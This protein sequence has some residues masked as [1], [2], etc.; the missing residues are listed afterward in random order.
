MQ[1]QCILANGEQCKRI[2]V[3]GNLCWQHKN[4]CKKLVDNLPIEN[5]Q[6]DILSMDIQPN[7]SIKI[8]KYNMISNNNNSNNI[9]QS[10]ILSFKTPYEQSIKIDKYNISSKKPIIKQ[11]ENYDKIIS[12]EEWMNRYQL[13]SEL[14]KGGFGITYS[15][16]DKLEDRN[17]AIKMINIKWS[18]G[19]DR[20]NRILDELKILESLSRFITIDECYPYI[21]CYY[22]GFI[23][24]YM[25]IEYVFLITELIEGYDLRSLIKD[26]IKPIY[27]ED[28][29]I[30]MKNL[31]EALVY[32]HSKG[33]AHVDIKPE[34]IIFDTNVN[35][36][37]IIDFGLAC[38]NDYTCSG[39]G[40]TEGYIPNF[41]IS[42]NLF[43]KQKQDIYAIGRVFYELLKYAQ[44]YEG[45]NDKNLYLQLLSITYKTSVK[46]EYELPSAEH[47]L[48]LINNIN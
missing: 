8:D 21:L 35:K 12:E 45:N 37:K 43:G 27:Y 33:Y 38:F 14:G 48:E 41:Y 47:L 10:D 40:G 9:K 13:S 15:G 46:D 20:I 30:C 3:N 24:T 18:G 7:K 6:S 34:N 39:R 1:C 17:V 4:K 31:T 23:S 44:I 36:Y 42:D 32:I 5:K 22:D 25:N 2:V 29:L 26:K 28:I 16:Y 11:L 19:Y